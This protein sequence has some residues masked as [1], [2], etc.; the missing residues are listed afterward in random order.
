M[1][2]RFIFDRDHHHPFSQAI[3][4]SEPYKEDHVFQNSPLMPNS[5]R[6]LLHHHLYL[7]V[8]WLV[9]SQWEQGMYTDPKIILQAWML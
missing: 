8:Q 7:P 1:Y 3:I 6:A 9:G 5:T 2:L 4:Q